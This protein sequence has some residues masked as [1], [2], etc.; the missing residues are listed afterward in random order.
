[1]SVTDEDVQFQTAKNSELTFT[2]RGKHL[3][4]AYKPSVEARQWVQSHAPRWEGRRGVL[5]FGMGCGYHVA[6]LKK[7]FSGHVVVL[8]KFEA[9]IQAALRVHPLDLHEQMVIRG[10]APEDIARA[11]LQE[12]V[13][14]DYAVLE[15][16]PSVSLDAAFYRNMKNF[17]LGRTRPGLEWLMSCRGFSHFRGWNS[18]KEGLLTIK[19]LDD[20]AFDK[21]SSFSTAWALSLAARDLVK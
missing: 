18:M 19:D 4:S 17:F 14:S 15:H 9:V 1:M 6:C 8:E 3:S 20:A 2:V 13:R 21:P 12:A 5:I 10:N 11:F 7:N 16:A